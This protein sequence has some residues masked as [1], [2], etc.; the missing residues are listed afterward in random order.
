MVALEFVC[1]LDT[2]LQ[3]YYVDDLGFQLDLS[4]IDIF[5][6]CQLLSLRR[7]DASK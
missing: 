6:V 2:E 3:F 4:G 1:E 5:N 7:V